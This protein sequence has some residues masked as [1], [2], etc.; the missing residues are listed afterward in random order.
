MNNPAPITPAEPSVPTEAFSTSPVVLSA[1]R[2]FWWIAGLSLVNSIMAHSGS[3]TNFVMGL[4]MTAFVDG[5]FEGNMLIGLVV[6]AALLGLFVFLGYQGQRG[7]LWAF[8]TGVAVYVFD[9]LVYVMI[10]DWMP[11]AFHALA[12]YFISKGIFALKE[13]SAQ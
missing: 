4:G 8:Y 1:A 10:A 12:I 3:N 9:A 5:M 2:W 7:K 13:A 6:N 11:V